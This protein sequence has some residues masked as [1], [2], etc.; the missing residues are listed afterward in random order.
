VAPS[1]CLWSSATEIHDRVSLNNYY[2]DN[3]EDFFVNVLK[4][5][6]LDVSMV[7]D[8]LL[9][10]HPERTTVQQAKDLLWQ[11]NALLAED[12][13]PK[14][15]AENLLKNPVLPVQYPNGNIK[16]CSGENEF[17]VVDRRPLMELF[18]GKIKILA[19]DLIEVHKL[20]PFL[21]WALLRR[22]CLSKVVREA[23]VVDPDSA[24][25]LSDQSRDIS[26][27]AQALTRYVEAN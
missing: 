13:K 11:M 17:A 18:R 2:D 24:F 7:Y 6:R 4:V 15:T 21:E 26:R 25:P 9:R 14:G 20:Q 16:L 23:S 3:M 27:K 12:E 19:F 10:V 8:E 5:S 22:R 1:E